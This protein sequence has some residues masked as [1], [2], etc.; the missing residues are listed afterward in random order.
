MIPDREILYK[1]RER[2]WSRVDKSGSC[3]IWTGGLSEDGYGL[4]SIWIDSKDKKIRAHRA[5][6][7]LNIGDIPDGMLVLH[8]CDN[9]PCVNPNHLFLGT[10][11]DNS[12]DK[13]AKG[14]QLKGEAMQLALKDK[15]LVGSNHPNSKLNEDQVR[16]IK[17]MLSRGMAKRQIAR[18]IGIDKSVII[19]ISQGRA[20]KHVG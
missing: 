19:S 10:H 1:Y 5:S 2:F 4:F 8:E 14:R 16:E 18:M 20:W 6:Y 11:K 12:D 15:V 7:M 17:L 13:V 9:P 3:W